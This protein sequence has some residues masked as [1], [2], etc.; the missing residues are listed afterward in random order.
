MPTTKLVCTIGPASSDRIDDLVAAGMSVA[1]VNLAHGDAADH[2]ASISAIRAAGDR[3]DREVAVLAD[4]PGPKIRLGQMRGGEA[5]LEAGHAFRIGPTQRGDAT[6]ATSN[7]PL[8]DHLRPGD[9]VLLADG[10]AELRVTATTGDTVETLVERSGIVRSRAGIAVPA[11]RISLPALTRDDRAALPRLVALG[12]DFLGLSF[13]RNAADVMS[14]REALADLSPEWAPAIVAK[15]ETRPAVE[16]MDAILG[17]ADAVMVARGDLGVELPFEEVPMVQKRLVQAARAAERPV[18]VATQMLESMVASPRPTRAEASDVANATLEGADAVMLSAE[19]AIGAFPIEAAR[20]A[21]RI[22]GATDSAE[23]DTRRA[24]SVVR[25]PVTCDDA[26]AIAQ[27]AVDLAGSAPDVKAIACFTRGGR[28]ATLLAGLRPPVPILAFSPDVHIRRRLS[29]VH[30]VLPR[31]IDAATD[32]Q[33]LEALYEAV[34]AI[35]SSPRSAIVLVAT[36]A[37]GDGRLDLLE[38]VRRG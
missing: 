33:I 21:M 35:G 22:V 5:T 7:H 34:A 10:A 19:T 14:L 24:A 23:G 17:A 3:A 25:T 1:R 18:I 32:Q 38:I 11:E 31:R 20:A 28:T 8:S 30:G 4:L 6:G 37:G 13:V 27:A 26:R 15:I 12:V 36:T 2:E 16:D 9:R 29:L